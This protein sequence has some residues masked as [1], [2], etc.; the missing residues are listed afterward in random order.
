MNTIQALRT[1]IRLGW[2]IITMAK[3][4]CLVCPFISGE[5]KCWMT[6]TPGLWQ[7]VGLSWP[8]LRPQ[9]PWPP[10]PLP[11]GNQQLSLSKTAPTISSG[12]KRTFKIAFTQTAWMLGFWGLVHGV[13]SGWQLGLTYSRYKYIGAIPEMFC[14]L[15]TCYFALVV[16][17]FILCQW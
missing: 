6:L 2:D 12:T 10:V 14:K 16:V 13:V 9:Q 15:G 3:Q 4:S 8:L 17:C 5:E 1:K 7:G 11:R